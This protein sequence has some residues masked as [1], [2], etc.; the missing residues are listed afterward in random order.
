MMCERMFLVV[1]TPRKISMA[2]GNLAEE[3]VEIV[4]G[5]KRKVFKLNFGKEFLRELFI[6]STNFDQKITCE[7]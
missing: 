3:S 2:A 1:F 5:M 6:K 7:K 4:L